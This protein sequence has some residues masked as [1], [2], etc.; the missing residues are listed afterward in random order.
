MH[1]FFESLSRIACASLTSYLELRKTF[2][3]LVKCKMLVML[4]SKNRHLIALSKR[5]RKR[6]CGFIDFAPNLKVEKPNNCSL[7]VLCS[8]HAHILYFFHS[9]SFTWY[10]WLLCFS[11]L[12]KKFTV[13]EGCGFLIE[14]LAYSFVMI[15]MLGPQSTLSINPRL[16]SASW[17]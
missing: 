6:F 10:L 5:T 8:T 9:L 15:I 3:D 17:F 2:R 13:P 4:I 12:I 16:T 14:S 11:L 7:S 1:R